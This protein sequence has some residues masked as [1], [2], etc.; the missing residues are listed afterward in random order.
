MQKD[1][2]MNIYDILNSTSNS[3]VA[4]DREGII[5]YCNDNV[6]DFLGVLKEEIEGRPV[7]DF[8]PETGITEVL[9]DGNPQL[10]RRLVLKGGTYITNR[11]P[12]RINGEI[13]GAVAVF[14]NITNLQVLIDELYS[15]NER[16]R[17]LQERLQTILELS[18]D[19]IIAVNKN[20]I[21]TMANKAF[22]GF[23][24]R[25]PSELIGRNVYDCYD[26]PLFP[27]VIETG[28]PEYGYVAELGGREIVANR[29]PIIKEGE[30]VGALGVIAFSKVED[31]YALAQKVESLREE[32]KY[33]KLEFERIHRE[34]FG[35]GQIIGEAPSIKILKDTTVRVAKTG[36]TVLIRGESGTGKE[37]FAHS[38]H[39]ESKRSSEPFVKVNCAAIP[40]NL[41]ESELFGYS[42]GAFTGAKKGGQVGK[43]ELAD[44][45]TIFLDEIGDMSPLMQAKLLRVLQDKTIERLGEGMPR[46][47]DVRVVAATNRNLEELMLKN[48]FRSD[49]YYRVSVVVL[50]VPP[51][52]ERT[53][54]IGPLAE[55]FIRRFNRQFGQNVVSI[56]PEV[57]D[58]LQRYEWPGNVRELQNVI[59]RAFNMMDG[60]VIRMKNLPLY[61][62]EKSSKTRVDTSV[63]R[64]LPYAIS[65][66][67]K[68]AIT[69][70]LKVT[71]GNRNKAAALLNIS[72][73]S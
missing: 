63:A 36:S 37:L 17:E 60:N 13:V 35:L 25:E 6:V 19:G 56:E 62:I 11:N 38:L 72:R 52:R 55:H 45:G 68:E 67:E 50:K 33:Y 59:E 41:L 21:I 8:F 73:A 70:A 26:K 46:Q 27:Q 30:I 61:L 42:E 7:L 69:E 65:Q 66:L 44:K 5:T 3:I 31:L 53:E 58:L 18:S 29:V 10:G 39:I 24:N 22:A 20:H 54:D 32:L 12:I 1:N 16:V 34:R 64:G 47:I 28:V 43:F 9:R 71:G 40:E 48:L 51:L 15:E 49:L 57:M 23:L 2:K 14:H 4:I